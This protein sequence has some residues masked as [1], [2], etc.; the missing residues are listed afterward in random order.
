[1]MLFYISTIPIRMSETILSLVL[2]LYE[3]FLKKYMHT[4]LQLSI[5]QIMNL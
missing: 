3:S 4:D 2:P 1:M 5:G